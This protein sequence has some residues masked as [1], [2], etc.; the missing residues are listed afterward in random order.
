MSVAAVGN[1]D[2]DEAGGAI[3]RP[4]ALTGGRTRPQ[5][6]IAI[7]ALLVTTPYG[8]AQPQHHYGGEQSKILALCGR[9]PKSLAEVAALTRLPL[10]VARVILSDMLSAGLVA[11]AGRIA[12]GERDPGRMELLDRV[13][14]GLRKL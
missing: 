10:G 1:A 4:Y 9:G 6:D 12:T 8:R 5:F 3:V 11:L 14:R 2:H 13:L 7:E